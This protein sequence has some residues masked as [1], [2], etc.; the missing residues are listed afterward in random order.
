[1]QPSLQIIINTFFGG[2]KSGSQHTRAAAAGILGQNIHDF[3][4][5]SIENKCH[6]LACL[7]GDSGTFPTAFSCHFASWLPQTLF[8]RQHG[9]MAGFKMLCSVFYI[10]TRF[11]Q[12]MPHSYDNKAKP[13]PE[14]IH[15]LSISKLPLLAKPRQITTSSQAK[16]MDRQRAMEFTSQGCNFQASLL[17]DLPTGWRSPSLKA[18]FCSILPLFSTFNIPVV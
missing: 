11:F 15:Q 8:A 13:R 9:M 3:V 16:A 17:L 18:T 12:S 5:W 10:R 7:H 2:G 14:W 6:G 4:G 1:M